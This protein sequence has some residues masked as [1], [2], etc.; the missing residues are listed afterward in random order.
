MYAAPGPRWPGTGTVLP[1]ELDLTL[2]NRRTLTGRLSSG[3]ALDAHLYVEYDGDT[4]GRPSSLA[5][6]L[7]VWYVY[8][9]Q[10]RITTLSIE[11]DGRFLEQSASRCQSSGQISLI[12]SRYNV[13]AWDATIMNCARSGSYSGLG[14][15][16]DIDPGAPAAF[17]VAMAS[18]T[19]SIVLLFER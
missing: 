3:T 8:D 18:A 1:I 7:G 6:L 2:V 10:I 12:D 17:L 11:P 15:L 19:N 16:V 9:G 13:Y 14:T 5:S 4:H